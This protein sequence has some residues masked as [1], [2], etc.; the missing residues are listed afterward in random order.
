MAGLQSGIKKWM[1]LKSRLSLS[2]SS[3]VESDVFRL[4]QLEQTLDPR[5][6]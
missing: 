6:A 5:G 4:M 3:T 2:D 1:L